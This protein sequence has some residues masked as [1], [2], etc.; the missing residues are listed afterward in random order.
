MGFLLLLVSKGRYE[1]EENAR[2]DG[3]RAET[4]MPRRGRKRA[5]PT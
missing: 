4:T 2:D 1:E 5:V 3:W